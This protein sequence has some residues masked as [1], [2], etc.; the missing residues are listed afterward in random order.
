VAFEEGKHILG[1]VT[2]AIAPPKQ[3]SGRSRSSF[4]R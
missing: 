1:S 3:L 4:S 2:L